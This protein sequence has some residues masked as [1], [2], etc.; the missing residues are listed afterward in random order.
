MASLAPPIPYFGGKQKIAQKIIQLFPEHSGYVEPF[1]GGLSVLLA[2]P[3]ARLEVVNDLNGHIV[4][5]W[6]VLRDQPEDL[7]RVC[8]LTPH[9]R[10]EF[11]LAD[12]GDGLSDLERAR[13]VW[14]LMTQG[15]SAIWSSTGWR[16]YQNG[17]APTSFEK[18][19]RA[20]RDRLHPA[21]D[22][23]RDVQIEQKP[24][25]EIITTYGKHVA[26][27][28]YVDPPYVG[29]TRGS[30]QRYGVEMKQLDMHAELLEKLD[31]V[32]AKV[33]LSGYAHPLYDGALS[34]WRRVEIAATTQVSARREVVWM[35]YEPPGWL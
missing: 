33:A 19:M 10:E 11:T 7:Q 24:A 15:R 27:L 17:A 21:A 4:T 20:Y 31:G 8:D 22:R 3:R 26:N 12:L 14:V 2:K 23:L 18:Y 34:G 25:L 5:F 9:S 30:G 29:E 1:A 32:A 16:H 35:N 6:R 28:L 13:R